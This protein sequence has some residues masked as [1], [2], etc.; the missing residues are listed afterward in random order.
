MENKKHIIIF[1]HG[2]GT[3]KDDRGLLTDIAAGFSETESILF[4]YNDVDEI[5]NTLTV[6]PLSE[7]AKM[8]NEVIKKAC[9]E[10]K[11][12]VIDVIGHSQGCLVVALAKPALVRKIIFTAPSLD[13]SIERTINMFKDRPDTEINLSGISKLGRKDGTI[14]LV[15]SQFW[16]ERKQFDP[17]PLYNELSQETELI[18]I[19]AKQD[20]IHGNLNTKGLNNNIEILEIDGNHQ[21]SGDARGVLLDKIRMLFNK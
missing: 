3:R 9:L 21:F 12:A 17:I 8:L 19:N 2:F 16:V 13:N 7:Q 5:K 20:D 18:I 4:D 1:S 10:N 6:P 15:P 11:D 14:T